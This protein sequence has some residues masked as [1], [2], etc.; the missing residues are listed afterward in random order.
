MLDS[1]TEFIVNNSFGDYLSDQIRGASEFVIAAKYS[2]FATAIMP[3]IHACLIFCLMIYG[4]RIVTGDEIS[5]M[6]QAG[7]TA[8]WVIVGIG[9]T[10]PSMFNYFIYTP[11]FALKDN[12]T[13][14]IMIGDTSDTIYTAFSNANYRMFAHAAN[15]MDKAGLTDVSMWVTAI[16]IYI[17]YGA[18]YVVFL[19]V[20][21]YCEMAVNLIM[22][23]GAFIIPLSGFQSMRGMGKSWLLS[24]FK[25][26][27]VFVVIAFIVSLLNIISDALITSLMQ[28]VYV[29]RNG[30]MDSNAVKLDS[31]IFGATL[32]IGAF[33]LYLMYQAMEFASEMTGGVMSDGKAGMTAISNTVKSSMKNMGV[34]LGAR[35]L[36]RSTGKAIASKMGG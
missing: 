9:L 1:I 10:T 12:L 21:L 30:G 2:G 17:I 13:A 25:Y 26:F 19:A 27:A 34:N 18:Y 36:R 15:I 5:T 6:K 23:L 35:S 3:T 24:L 8:V 29:S 20:T 11:Y 22:L 4:I 31:P 16:A 33:G 32:A 14:F 7:I 28:E